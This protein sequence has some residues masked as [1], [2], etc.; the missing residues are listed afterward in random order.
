MDMGS[1]RLCPYLG[2]VAKTVARRFS[3]PQPSNLYTAYLP[4]RVCPACL[5]WQRPP[6]P[7]EN[8]RVTQNR[9][10]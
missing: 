6:P 7:D 4:T 1:K 10:R 3:W 2:G 5:P 8:K 9:A